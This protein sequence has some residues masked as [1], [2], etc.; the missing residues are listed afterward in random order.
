MVEKIGL[1]T[2]LSSDKFQ[3]GDDLSLAS[4][5]MFRQLM[6]YDPNIDAY[7]ANS[8]IVYSLFNEWANKVARSKGRSPMRSPSYRHAQVV[9]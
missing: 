3:G 8:D 4:P 5:D 6:L 2:A 9:G 7:N 1:V